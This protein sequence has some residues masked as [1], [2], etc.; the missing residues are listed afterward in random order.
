MVNSTNSS[1]SAPLN[2]FGILKSGPLFELYSTPGTASY[3]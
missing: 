2:S 3:G 1:A